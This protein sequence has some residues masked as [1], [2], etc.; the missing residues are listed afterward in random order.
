VSQERHSLFKFH[1]QSRWFTERHQL[2]LS[3]I[4]LPTVEELADYCGAINSKD[5]PV[6]LSAIKGCADFLVTGDNKDFSL[7][8][9]SNQYSFT[10]V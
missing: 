9:D 10:V 5:L 7:I 6:L 1:R 3:I 4:P 8:N 2:S